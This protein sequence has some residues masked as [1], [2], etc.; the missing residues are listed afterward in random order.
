MALNLANIRIGF[1]CKERWDGMVGDAKVRDCAKCKRAVFNLSEMTT[2]E[3]EAVLA[4]RGVKPCVRFYR[5]PDGTVMT[6]DAC[7]TAARPERRRLAVVAGA[8][9]GTALA[10]AP[11]MADP[12]ADDPPSDAVPEAGTDAGTDAARDAAPDSTARS[13]DI[14]VMGEPMEMGVI[15]VRSEVEERPTIEWSTWARLGY[16]LAARAPS[17]LARTLHPQLGE[18]DST[19]EAALGGELTLAI[20]KHGDIRIGAWSELRTTSGPLVGGELVL[21]DLPPRPYDSTINGTGTIVLRAGANEHVAT[22]A[23]GFGY[24]GS[25]P[26]FDPWVSWARHLVGA[27]IVT[28]TTYSLDHPHDWSVIV[29]LEIEPIG[30]ITKALGLDHA[31]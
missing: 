7:A 10:A 27:R 3:A 8:F 28:S 23:V 6:S 24:V 21:E 1:A 15:V 17:S 31:D 18:V 13:E 14:E 12:P 11:A 4:R 19:W 29:G 30:V 2:A 22:W 16:G 25:F 20:A 26:R 5:R 9:A